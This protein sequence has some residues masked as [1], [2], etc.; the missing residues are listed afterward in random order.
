[1][2]AMAKYG[3]SVISSLGDTMTAAAA[4]QFRGSGFLKGVMTQWAGILNGRPRGE[5]AEISYLLGEG[6]DGLLGHIVNANVA[7]DGIVGKMGRWQE[8]FFKWNSLTWWTDVNRAVAARTISAEMG[9]HLR[10][11]WDAIDPAYRHVMEMNGI[12]DT[13]WSV[14]QKA[15]MEGPNGNPYMTPDRIAD[16]GDEHFAPLIEQG[17]TA[18]DARR[19]LQL[20]LLRYV[21]DET[22]NSIVEHD[23]RSKRTTTRGMRPGTAGGEAIRFVMQAKSY[24]IAFSQRVLGR[25]IFGNRPGANLE[26]AR[27]ISSLTAG[28]GLAGYLSLV[29]NDTLHGY[30]PPR[31]PT[32]G[33]TWVAALQKSGG[34][35]VWGDYLFAQKSAF[36]YSFLET[37]AGPTIGD[38]AHLAEIGKGAID[39]GAGKALD[40]PNAKFAGNA[41]VSTLIGNTPYANLYWLRP[42]MDFLFLNALREAIKPGYLRSVDRR[43]EQDFGQK[44]LATAAGL[45]RAL[46]PLGKA[47]GF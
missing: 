29:A 21:G 4:N 10:K 32:D 24:P 37:L 28:L 19:D 14:M 7:N 2:Q 6:F 46:D 26:M 25:T 1:M 18:E 15:V 22:S 9:M 43:R 8:Q 35:G 31:D 17:R 11:S 47:Q 13:H 44:P 3:G 41:A 36:G 34:L 40:D 5:Q 12:T 33:A 20:T 39:Y 23:N 16:L 38:F 45:P 42:A 27:N 30:W